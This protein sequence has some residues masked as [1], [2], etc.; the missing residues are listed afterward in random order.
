M[1]VVPLRLYVMLEVFDLNTVPF[2]GK[3]DNFSY[4]PFANLKLSFQ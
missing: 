4:L 1:Y 3:P 2:D